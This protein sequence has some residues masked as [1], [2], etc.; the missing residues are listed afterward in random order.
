MNRTSRRRERRVPSGI[1]LL[2][3]VWER[4]DK[5]AESQEKS[6]SQVVEEVLSLHLP[7]AANSQEADADSQ[8]MGGQPVAVVQGRLGR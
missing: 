2:P 3:S 7:C 5:L 1:S 4:V 8:D 6:R